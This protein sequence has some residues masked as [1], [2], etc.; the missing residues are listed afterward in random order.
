MHTTP[1]QVPLVAEYDSDDGAQQHTLQPAVV[2]D[3]FAQALNTALPSDIED[4]DADL[5]P[6]MEVSVPRR[7]P[8]PPQPQPQAECS[9]TEMRE[10]ALGA[11]M[12]MTTEEDCTPPTQ[13]GL[14]PAPHRL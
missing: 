4:D 2:V 5:A 10:R 14:P 13:V 1:S 7:A 12:A 6:E 8:S 9:I 3:E 11:E